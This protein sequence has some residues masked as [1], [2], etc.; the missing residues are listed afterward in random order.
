MVISSLSVLSVVFETPL[1]P[2]TPQFNTSLKHKRPTC[3]QPPKFLRSSP[4]L[5]QFNTYLS[6]TSKTPQFHTKNASVQHQKPLRSI[7]KFFGFRCWN[8]GFWVL[9]RCVPCAELR[10][11]SGLKIC[12]NSAK[13]S[14][15]EERSS[16]NVLNRQISIKIFAWIVPV[17]EVI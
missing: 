5:P 15:L 10:C 14:F 9:K 17:N 13:N 8:E 11:G 4:K 7:T 2:H 1:V 6:S 16:Y 3:F 12:L